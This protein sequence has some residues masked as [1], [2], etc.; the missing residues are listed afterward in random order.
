MSR[1]QNNVFVILSLIFYIVLAGFEKQSKQ[2]KDDGVVI[3]ALGIG[4]N[5]DVAELKALASDESHVL[6]FTSFKEM[7]P[8]N[9]ALKVALAICSGTR[10]VSY[11]TSS[12]PS[13]AIDLFSFL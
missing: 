11:Q 7:S 2:L 3:F 13:L 5:V 8:I 12:L 1:K 4:S 10:H 9:N 6:R